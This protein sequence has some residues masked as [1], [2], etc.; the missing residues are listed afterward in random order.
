MQIMAL[1]NLPARCIRCVFF[2]NRDLFQLCKN[3]PMPL[4]KLIP[5]ANL[6]PNLQNFHEAVKLV[7]KRFTLQIILAQLQTRVIIIIIIITFIFYLYMPSAFF[8]FLQSDWLQRRAVFYDILTVV[9][10]SY[11]F[12][13]SRGVKAIFKFKTL[14]KKFKNPPYRY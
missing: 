7:W 10:K 8:Y 14:P 2:T 13:K 11:F 12:A 4:Q 1:Q 5:G 9:Q 3:T 6:F